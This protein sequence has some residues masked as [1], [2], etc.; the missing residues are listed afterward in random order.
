MLCRCSLTALTEETVLS[1]RD[2]RIQL[3]VSAKLAD[4][5]VHDITHSVTFNVEPAGVVEIDHAA[6]VIPIADGKATITAM[7][8]SGQTATTT[9]NVINS[10]NEAAVH[11]PGSIVPI[12]TKLGC[13][14]GGCHGKAAGQNGFKLSLLG[15][16]PSEDYEH[17]VRES[18]GRRLTPAAPSAACCC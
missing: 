8:P 15:F 4:Q 1:G 11:F 6:L 14:G 5:S 10:G 3:V 18:R 17:L 16:E 9:V 13:N 12:F 7:N 2:A